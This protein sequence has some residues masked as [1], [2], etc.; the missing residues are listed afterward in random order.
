MTTQILFTFLHPPPPSTPPPLFF[1]HAVLLLGVK[2][3]SLLFG[4]GRGGALL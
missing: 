3:P 1:F 4:M 2:D